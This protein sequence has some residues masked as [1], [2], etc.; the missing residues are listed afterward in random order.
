MVPLVLPDRPAL[1]VLRDRPVRPEPLGP[2]E[3]LARR[4]PL[5][6]P[7]RLAQ[8]EPQEALVRQARLDLLE[9]LVRRVP[10]AVLGPLVLRGRLDPRVRRAQELP[11]LRGQ[12]VLLVPQDLRALRGRL[13][14][15][16]PTA[17][18]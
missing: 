11:A 9:Q 13:A 5:G 17:P 10:R 18:Q 14:R 2:Q 15:P 1:R 4:V 16:A 6:Q 12:R 8:P 7:D 3:A